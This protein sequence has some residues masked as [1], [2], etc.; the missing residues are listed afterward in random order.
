MHCDGK[1]KSRS[2]NTSYCSIGHRL[3]KRYFCK[4]TIFNLPGAT[5][6]THRQQR[7]TTFFSRNEVYIKKIKYGNAH[8]KILYFLE[9]NYNFLKWNNISCIFFHTISRWAIH[10]LYLCILSRSCA[11]LEN[12]RL[13][14]TKCR[15]FNWT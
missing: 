6:C 11:N 13:A 12:V 9:T 15:P 3:S 2:H 1:W 4:Q 8:V 5:C 14:L 7:L 10:M